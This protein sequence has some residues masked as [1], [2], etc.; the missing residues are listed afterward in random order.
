MPIGIQTFEEIREDGYVYVDKTEYV[1]RLANE[2]KPYFLS[3]PRRFGKSLLLSTIK[4]YFQGKKELFSGLALEKLEKDWIE[5]PV[6]HLDFNKGGYPNGLKSLNEVLDA[7]FAALEA[8]WGKGD[9]ET[10]PSYRFYNLIKRAYQ[11]TGRKVVVLV[12]EYDKPLLDTHGE[13]HEEVRY[14]LRTVYGMLKSADEYL[15]FVLLTGVTKF[16]QLTLYSGM[17]QLRDISMTEQYGGICG[18]TEVELIENFR[19]E[20]EAMATK[21]KLTFDTMMNKLRHLYDGYHFAQTSEGVFNPFSVLNAFANQRLGNFWFQTGTP[22]FLVST[23]KE[24]QFDFQVFS[25]DIFADENEIMDY[26]ADNSNPMPLLYQTGYLTIKDVEKETG[27][28]ILGFPNEEVEYGLLKSFLASYAPK[29]DLLRE[30]GANLF[31]A[32]LRKQDMDAFMT[33]LRAFFSSIPYDLIDTTEQ[34]ERHYQTVFFLLFSLLGEYVQ[35][36]VKSAAGR[37]DAVVTTK[38][39]VFVFEFKL[40]GD[41]SAET[42]DQLVKAALKQIDDKGYLL[43]YTASGKRL[44]KIGAAFDAATR[45]LGKWECVAS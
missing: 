41:G 43:S 45:T 17:N 33:R 4:A 2:G 35:S 5:Y 30:F 10:Q 16:S 26:R 28:L 3:R 44:V 20:I 32:D 6:F 7:T 34:T 29:T 23:L 40:A 11:K 42:V 38:D 21:N 1:Y 9:E 18:I 37:A 31:Y 19:P 36:E 25:E 14:Q 24:T 22:T 13:A 39:A 15:K 8:E 27:L 12:D